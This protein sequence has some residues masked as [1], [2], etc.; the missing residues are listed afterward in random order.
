LAKLL[1]LAY[2]FPATQNQING[3]AMT[4]FLCIEEALAYLGLNAE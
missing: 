3:D 1:N 2:Y 4:N